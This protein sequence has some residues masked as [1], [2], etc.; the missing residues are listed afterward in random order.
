LFDR[1]V[2]NSNPE[3]LRLKDKTDRELKGF[4][5]GFLRTFAVSLLDQ[6]FFKL[7]YALPVA[8]QY[9]AQQR[10]QQCL[11]ALDMGSDVTIRT[12]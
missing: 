1:G 2:H 11:Q 5:T 3:I 6:M 10:Q 7:A 8:R 12:H 9:Q 4:A